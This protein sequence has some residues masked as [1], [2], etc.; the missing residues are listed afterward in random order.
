MVAA[1]RNKVAC[2]KLW[3]IKSWEITLQTVVRN[4]V[5]FMWYK[6]KIKLLWESN[7][8]RKRRLQL[9]EKRSLLWDIKYEKLLDK[10]FKVAIMRISSF[11]KKSCII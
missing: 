9:S 2:K 10:R 1:V 3:V 6:V 5:A 8:Y 4:K 11:K 7:N